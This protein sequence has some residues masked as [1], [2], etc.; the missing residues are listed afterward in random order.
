MTAAT[1]AETRKRSARKVSSSTRHLETAAIV[2]EVDFVRAV[3]ESVSAN[4]VSRERRWRVLFLKATMVV[5]KK[6]KKMMQ[7]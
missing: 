7:R 5:V 2:G 6:T 3:G 4:G 1:I